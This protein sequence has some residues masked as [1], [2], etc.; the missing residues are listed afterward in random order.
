MVAA[1]RVACAH[2]RYV[3]R[4]WRALCREQ[5]RRRSHC[6]RAAKTQERRTLQRCAER[7]RPI[8]AGMG[9]AAGGT[10]AALG[11]R[12]VHLRA[13]WRGLAAAAEAS[14]PIVSAAAGRPAVGC[15][16]PTDLCNACGMRPA[17]DGCGVAS[18]QPHGRRWAGCACVLRPSPGADV[19]C[20]RARAYLIRERVRAESLRRRRLGRR[21]RHAVGGRLHSTFGFRSAAKLGAR[22][23]ACAAGTAAWRGSAT[24]HAG[25]AAAAALCAGTLVAGPTSPHRRTERVG[26][27]MQGADR[28][29]GRKRRIPPLQCPRPL[30]RTA[31]TA[32]GGGGICT[33]W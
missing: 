12:A 13:A 23:K 1:R 24:N 29:G 2:R 28:R 19:G 6:G 31:R 17:I 15:V 7:L 21:Q 30:P 27:D 18:T 14:M 5:L 11:D 20:V 22:I 9:C 4:G 3:P 10:S 8:S 26:G 32:T 16:V 25:T 33:Q